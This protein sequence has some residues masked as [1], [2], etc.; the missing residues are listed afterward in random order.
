MQ[1]H[2]MTSGTK[3]RGAALRAAILLAV[4]ILL[5]GLALVAA[6]NP[7]ERPPEQAATEQP[8]EKTPPIM[9]QSR[10]GGSS[11]SSCPL[12]ARPSPAS[13]VS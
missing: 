8:A 5:F 4:P 12:T 13:S 11:A 2:G 7:L 10:S 3:Q 6:E 9:R 1:T